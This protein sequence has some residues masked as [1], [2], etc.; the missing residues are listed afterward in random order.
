MPPFDFN[1]INNFIAKAS[2][3]ALCDAACQKDR[4]SNKLRQK[5]NDAVRNADTAP[6]NVDI[7]F[8]KYITFSQ[9]ELAYNKAISQQIRQKAEEMKKHALQSFQNSVNAIKDSI[10]SYNIIHTNYNNVQNLHNRLVKKNNKAEL[11]LKNKTSTSLI[12]DRKSY[13]NN[14]QLDSLKMYATI[15]QFVYGCITLGFIML[16]V[17]LYVKHKV[18]SKDILIWFAILVVFPFISVPLYNCVLQL[19][20][21]L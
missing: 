5:Y 17:F 18:F 3:N 8:K 19:L 12:N 9:G 2:D 14:Q 1:K 11:L 6:H 16:F 4:T 7:A 15:L 21:V 20:Q 10:Q 13:Y